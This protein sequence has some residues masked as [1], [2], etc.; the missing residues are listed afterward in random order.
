MIPDTINRFKK[1]LIAAS[2]ILVALFIIYF[3]WSLLVFRVT[4]TTP[5]NNSK[6]NTGSNTIYIYFNKELKNDPKNITIVAEGDIVND[7][8]IDKNKISINLKNTENNKS[9]TVILRNIVSVDNSTISL[10]PFKFTTGYV[11]END[12][13]KDEKQQLQSQTDKG[14]IDDPIILVLPYNNPN[15]SMNTFYNASGDLIIRVVITLS[16]ADIREGENIAIDRYKE[17]AKQYLI[18]NDIDPNDYQF[19]YIIE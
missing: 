7:Y 3:S 4:G 17:Q 9:Y 11:S 5:A 12:L 6:V 8:S 18:S 10:Y 2:V 19:E 16:L 13:S 15:I 1:P 14:N